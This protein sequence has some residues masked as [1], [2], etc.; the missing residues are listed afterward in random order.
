MVG[1][2]Y[3]TG[4]TPG[5]DVQI[6]A[7]FYDANNNFVATQSGTPFF[8][9]AP[10]GNQTIPFKLIVTNA[11]ASITRYELTMTAQSTSFIQY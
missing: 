6:T 10:V 8:S 1:E 3:N 9:E 4:V 11:P 2:I 5:Y 7:K